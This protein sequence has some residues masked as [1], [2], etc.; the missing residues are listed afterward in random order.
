M[1]VF[2]PKSKSNPETVSFDTPAVGN[3]L[4]YTHYWCQFKSPPV[5]NIETG[6]KK[7][8]RAF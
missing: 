2:L 3:E 4:T 5:L 8:Q 1:F 7:N 6:R